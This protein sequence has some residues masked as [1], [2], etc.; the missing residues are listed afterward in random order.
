MLESL[1]TLKYFNRIPEGKIFS[2]EEVPTKQEPRV[3]EAACCAVTAYSGSSHTVF[4]V[5]SSLIQ[6]GCSVWA[7]NATNTPS[8]LKC[9]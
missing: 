2:R 3:R 8:S 7:L 1:N 5:T 9:S 4:T 6:Q